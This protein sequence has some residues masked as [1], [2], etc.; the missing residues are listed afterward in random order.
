MK[1]T[2]PIF[3]LLLLTLSANAQ[4]G[5]SF[6]LDTQYLFDNHEFNASGGEIIPSETFHF[7][8]FTPC[9]SWSF[10]E[11]ADW[12]HSISFGLDLIKDA[13]STVP[14][15]EFIQET[16]VYINSSF[17]QGDTQFTAVFGIY[18]RRLAEGWYSELI[19]S[20]ET[21]Q[22][23]FN[24]EGTLLKYR[25][26][27][28]FAELG[29]DWMGKYGYDTKERFQLFTAGSWR[30]GELLTLGWCGSFYHYAGSVIAPG[31]V[32]NHIIQ[33]YALL[34][35]S[36]IL[37]VIRLQ[38]RASSFYS[39]QKDRVREDMRHLHGYELELKAQWKSF[40]FINS[41]SLSDDM[42]PFYDNCDTAGNIYGDNLYRGS[43]F[44]FGFYDR[45]EL[46]W[47]PRLNRRTSL[48]L[49]ARLHYNPSGCLGSEQRFSLFFLL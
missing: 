14:F 2:V 47:A 37:P 29:M 3:F 21:V 12:S 8:R 36:S 30:L 10:S 41:A 9:V 28:F 45:V 4:S 1:K 22:T 25:E 32:D 48:K 11:S 38:L 6:S 40:Y 46:G 27:S 31:V 20:E 19:L 44:Y 42:L 18:P 16:P 33:P 39:Y 17:N 23:D 5:I 7:V 24:L 34:D 49:S 35:L 26:G 13:G 15:R 43:K